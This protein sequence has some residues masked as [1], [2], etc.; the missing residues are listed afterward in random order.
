M[1]PLH[2][3]CPPAPGSYLRRLGVAAALGTRVPK[4]H[5][6]LE[7]LGAGAAAGRN[8]GSIARRKSLVG[9]VTLKQP[10]RAAFARRS[11]RQSLKDMGFLQATT[12]AVQRRR[13]KVGWAPLLA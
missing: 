11:F 1:A 2:V 5:L 3:R 7:Q 12:Q 6:A 10:A 13:E 9:T 8:G 4:L